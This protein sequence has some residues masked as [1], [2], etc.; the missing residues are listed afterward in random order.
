VDAAPSGSTEG[1]AY[2]LC[3]SASGNGFEALRLLRRRYD[4]TNPALASRLRAQLQR[5]ESV[6][7]KL[8]LKSSTDYERRVKA[9]FNAS[10]KSVN[11]EDKMGKSSRVSKGAVAYAFRFELFVI[12]DLRRLEKVHRGVRGPERRRKGARPDS[13]G[14]V[15]G[16]AVAGLERLL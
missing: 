11:D 10:G 4:P 14:P 6:P 9:Y 15:G 12:S 3:D 13:E 16:A 7:Q 8:L 1:Q 5:Q 2:D